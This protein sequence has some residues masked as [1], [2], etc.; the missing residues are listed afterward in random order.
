MSIIEEIGRRDAG[1][2]SLRSA[3][4]AAG[5]RWSAGQRHLVRLI[6]ELD[7]SGEWAADGAASCA[8]W[9]ASALDVEL[10]TAREW[11]RIGRSFVELDVIGEALADRRLSYSKVRA[12]TRVATVANQA[13]LCALAERVP[14]GRLAYAV[15]DWLARHETAAETKARHKRTRSFSSH[16]ALDGMVVGSFR[17]PPADAAK[18]TAPIDEMVWRRRPAAKASDD[19]SADASSVGTRMR[20]PT[21]AQQRADAFME[22]ATG[23]GGD[24]V[25]EIVM[26]VRSDGCSLDDGTP[27]AGTVVEQIASEAFLR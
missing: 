11:L 23:G 7:V 27:I 26:H 24:L 3:V 14:A 25:T 4:I 5:E 19:A 18:L 10:C 12:L 21:I 9:I 22:I 16:L 2:G 1:D 8:H 6:R 15:A 17:L 13:E 20:W